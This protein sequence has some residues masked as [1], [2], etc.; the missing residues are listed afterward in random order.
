MKQPMKLTMQDELPLGKDWVY[1]VK[2]DGFRVI[3]T[4]SIDGIELT[5]RNGKDLTEKFPEITELAAIHKPEHLPLKLDGELVILNTAYQ[6]NFP[7][8]QQ[9][10][11]LRNEKKIMDAAEKR[12][13]TF[14][15]FDILHEESSPYDRRRADLVE[16][17]TPLTTDRLRIIDSFHEEETVQQL[18]FLHLAEGIVA[19]HKQSAYN[20]DQRSKQWIKFKNWRTIPCFLTTYDEANDYYGC[21]V[22]VEDEIV[23][24]GKF[25]HGLTSDQSDTLRT[26]FKENGKKEATIWSLPPSV[27]VEVDCL[28]VK[29][30]EFREP[31]FH[32]FRFD[33]SP[34]EC[35]YLSAEWDLAMFP[36]NVEVSNSEKMLWPEQSKRNYL[37]Y[38]RRIAPYMLPFLKEKKLTVIRYPDGIEA[39]SFFQKH[40]PDHAPGYVGAWGESGETYLL[41]SNLNTLLWLG[42]Q[43]SIE[44]HTPFQKA[45]GK[46]PDEIVFDLDP[47]NSEAFQVA[48]LAAKLLKHLLDELGVQSFVKT[49]G[50]KGLQVHIPIPEGAMTYK[51]TRRFTESLAGL[52][53]RERPDLF[54]TERLKK[55]RKG[56][57][58]LDYVQHAEGKTIV[59]PYSVRAKAS[60]AVATPLFWHELTD[61]LR[62]EHFPFHKM[63][64]RVETLGCPFSHYDHARKEQPIQTMKTL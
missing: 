42:N 34:E 2:F 12:P 22:Y 41:C 20:Y 30:K 60:A 16:R 52:L 21:A 5:S 56:R 10:G 62:P 13:A 4:W 26:F 51:E 19:K 25:K 45:G 29:D 35:T 46:D 23:S 7:L 15:A 55:H 28:E 48:V 6:A 36:T 32:D 54:T 3:L 57:L 53:E 39:T 37:L 44:F 50:S 38:L 58:Y 14:I 47:P 43:A 31:L 9:R 18:V 17:L 33:L 40:L 49:S 61:D 1:E 59:A 11:R 64:E 63:I 8:L 24:I 27:C